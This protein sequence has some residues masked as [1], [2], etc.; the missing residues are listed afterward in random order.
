VAVCCTPGTPGQILVRE[1]H[2]LAATLS[3]TAA[4]LRQ[5]PTVGFLVPPLATVTAH[6]DG[7]G[8]LHRAHRGCRQLAAAALA[9]LAVAASGLAAPF[10]ILLDELLVRLAKLECADSDGSSSLA[11]LHGDSH[12]RI[13][14][15]P[16]PRSPC[17]WWPPPS[18]SCC[19]MAWP[20]LTGNYRRSDHPPSVAS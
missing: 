10:L 8:R 9:A 14:S 16:L 5:V 1:C 19:P 15:T 2:V 6:T 7:V 4:R 20:P 17:S 11:L 12:Q 18:P 13:R 3:T